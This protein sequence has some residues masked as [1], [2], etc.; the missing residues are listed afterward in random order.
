MQQEALVKQLQEQHF[1]QYVRQVYE[2]QMKQQGL[3][4]GQ[5]TQGQVAGQQQLGQSLSQVSL[6]LCE[7]DG[8]MFCKHGRMGFRVTSD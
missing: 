6:Y 7:A 3:A 2:S 4:Q 8:R 1:Q 5:T